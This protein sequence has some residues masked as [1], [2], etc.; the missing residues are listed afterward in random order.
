MPC[1]YLNTFQSR[2]LGSYLF[3][4]MHHASRRLPET[5]RIRHLT[6]IDD[7]SRFVSKPDSIFGSSQSFGAWM[8]TLKI[9]RSSGYGA[10]FIDQLVEP[11]LDDIK[12]LCN[13]WLIVGGVH[14]KGN[15]EDVAVAMSLD[16]QQKE[17]LGRLQTRECICFCPTAHSQHPYPIHGFVPE[18]EQP[19]SEDF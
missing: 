11:I 17:M 19:M 2:F 8:H 3:L 12:Q 16:Q 13:F 18:V 5:T 6:V 4:F 14:G 15:Q 10:L 9:L 1:P 7:A